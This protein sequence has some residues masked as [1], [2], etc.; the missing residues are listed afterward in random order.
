MTGIHLDSA[1]EKSELN[2]LF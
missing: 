1:Q 2:F